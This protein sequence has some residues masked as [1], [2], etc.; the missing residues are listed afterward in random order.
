MN[1]YEKEN[2]ILNDLEEYL[3]EK[4]SIVLSI[5]KIRETLKLY[6]EIERAYNN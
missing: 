6:E 1:R 3:K 4:H 2:K 5:E